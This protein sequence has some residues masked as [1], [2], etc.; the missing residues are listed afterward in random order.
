M[1]AAHSSGSIQ[2]SSF[3]QKAEKETEFHPEGGV[4]VDV[5]DLVGPFSFH[6][7]I[8]YIFM[9]KDSPFQSP[10]RDQVD[11]EGTCRK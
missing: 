10:A 2:R 6:G 1:Y 8:V 4:D 5:C 11:N 7:G 3:P 9:R